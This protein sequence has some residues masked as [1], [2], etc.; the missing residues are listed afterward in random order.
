MHSALS[1]LSVFN[2]ILLDSLICVSVPNE[3]SVLISDLHSH[4]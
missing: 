1:L 2:E 4:F 3:L